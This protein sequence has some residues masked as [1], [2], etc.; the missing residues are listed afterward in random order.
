MEEAS[1]SYVAGGV[2]CTVR[3]ACSFVHPSHPALSRPISTMY[4]PHIP[5]TVTTCYLL[6]AR[7]ASSGKCT[8]GDRYPATR[9]ASPMVQVQTLT[10]KKKRLNGAPLVSAP[11]LR[12]GVARTGV[13]PS[14]RVWQT[15][16]RDGGGGEEIALCFWRGEGRYRW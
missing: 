2:L 15:D 14:V 10:S 16:V 3:A 6:C 9:A 4:V 12:E 7:S 1:A 5:R 8:C 13:C 11:H